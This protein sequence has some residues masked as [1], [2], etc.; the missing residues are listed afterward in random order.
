MSVR[1]LLVNDNADHIVSWLET[2]AKAQ[3]IAVAENGKVGVAKAAEL[4]GSYDVILMDHDMPLMN[5]A[6]ATGLILDA[7]PDAPIIG[8]SNSWKGLDA[9]YEAGA[10][11]V[12]MGSDN[13]KL[14]ALL[15]FAAAGTLADTDQV[16]EI[17]Y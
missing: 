14:K 6:E 3:V 7:N 16:I 4:A 2:C 8:Y 1:V 17:A 10:L 13:E 15:R 9:I 11:W 12:C 5:G